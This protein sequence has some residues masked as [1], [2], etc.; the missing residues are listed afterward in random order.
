MSKKQVLCGLGIIV[1][2]ITII[3]IIVV[4]VL[5]AVQNGTEE[6]SL[7]LE[8]KLDET[9]KLANEETTPKTGNTPKPSEIQGVS[10][11]M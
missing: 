9:E 1:G 3:V 5:L 4:I 11:S 2:A 10:V 6:E 8:F 7:D